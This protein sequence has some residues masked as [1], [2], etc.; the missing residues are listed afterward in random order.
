M[1]KHVVMAMAIEQLP[2]CVHVHEGDPKARGGDDPLCP[3]RLPANDDEHTAEKKRRGQE[4]EERV[5]CQVVVPRTR[6][7]SGHEKRDHAP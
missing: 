6:E 7:T 3:A 1:A 2:G 5:E 4:V